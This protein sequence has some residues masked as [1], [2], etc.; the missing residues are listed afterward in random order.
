M[1][2]SVNS[3]LPDRLSVSRM[4]KV[5]PRPITD[6]E[7]A[8]MTR[9]ADTLIPARDGMLSGSAVGN[10]EALIT[11]ATAILDK[12]FPDLVAA[13]ATLAP[14]PDDQLWDVLESMSAKNDPGFVTLTTVISG[15][16]LYSDEI[17]KE[18]NYPVP[19]RNPPDFFDAADEL[20]SGILDQ[21]MASDFTY[22][23]VD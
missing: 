4:S 5:P 6:E 3:E 22:I 20:S 2:N 7:M 17:R 23:K 10:F 13:L 21:V 18:L 14:V 16:Y 12:S 1:A 8:T 19:H 15:A 11:R 9:V